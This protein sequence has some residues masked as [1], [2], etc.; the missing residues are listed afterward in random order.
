MWRKARIGKYR[1][2]LDEPTIY[3]SS[4]DEPKGWRKEMRAL[5]ALAFPDW[6]GRDSLP[7]SR[8]GHLWVFARTRAHEVLVGYAYV[9]WIAS[10][11]DDVDTVV[12]QIAVH[13]AWQ[14]R[15]IGRRLVAEVAS[16]AQ[17]FGRRRLAA[18]P[19]VGPD[20]ERRE[21]WL[22]SLGFTSPWG[23][24]LTASPSEVIKAVHRLDQEGFT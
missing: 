12:E 5:N 23:R 9:Y 20:E 11:D 24:G 6:D 19:L 17:R 16:T 21:L 1:S 13:P 7:P 14:G 18:A 4:A 2:M 22:R 8:K 15:G 10:V 3:T